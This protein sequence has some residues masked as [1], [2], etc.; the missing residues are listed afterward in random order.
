MT[1]LSPFLAPPQRLRR[2]GCCGVLVQTNT[3]YANGLDVLR[4][5]SL[6]QQNSTYVGSP[7]RDVPDTSRQS[8][9]ATFAARA[10]FA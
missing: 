6:R 10:T 8:Q 9:L 3:G 1:R 2:L 5:E 4:Q 7:V